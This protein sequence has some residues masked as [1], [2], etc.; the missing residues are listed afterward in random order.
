MALIG[1]FKKKIKSAKNIA[2]ITRAMQLVAASKM[3]KAQ[4]SAL[5]GKEY[6]DGVY[7]LSGLVSKYYDEETNKLVTKENKKEA[8]TMIVLIAP[9]KGLCGALVTNLSK[10]V[11]NVIQE[12]QGHKPTDELDADMSSSINKGNST[13]KV[14]GGRHKIMNEEKNPE[15]LVIGKKAKQIASR[16]RSN[17]IADFEMGVSSPKYDMVPPIARI[18]EDR[19]TGGLNDRVIVVYSEFINTMEQRPKTKNLLPL[20]I[21][22]GVSN[23]KPEYLSDYKF[24]PSLE[25]IANPLFEMYLEIEIYQLLLESYA[26]EQSARM[27]AM[28]N[29]T[30]NAS[31][32]IEDLTVEFNKARQSAITNELLDIQNAVALSS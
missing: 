8:K 26:S 23:D 29:A 27:V 10:F 2:K 28:K 22:E 15:F 32:L 16:L 9:E 31:S 14:V 1:A 7:S 21:E 24:E 19:F 4:N 17:I 20:T 25:E 6:A 3:K 5:S 11:Y 18:I 13:S 12:N 30:D